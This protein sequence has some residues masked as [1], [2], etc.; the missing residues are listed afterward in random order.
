MTPLKN[1]Q[2][3]S[4]PTQITKP[5]RL[6]KMRGGKPA[7]TLLPELLEVREHANREEGQDEEHDPQGIGFTHRRGRLRRDVRWGRSAR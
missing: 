6:A 3:I 1:S 7:N 5:N 2:E 4:S